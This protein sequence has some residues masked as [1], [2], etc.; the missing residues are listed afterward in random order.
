MYGNYI[1]GEC[2]RMLTWRWM[3]EDAV[4][5]AGFLEGE[6][7]HTIAREVRVKFLEATPTFD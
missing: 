5:D 3:D 1:L 2:P 7:C 6:F 4:A